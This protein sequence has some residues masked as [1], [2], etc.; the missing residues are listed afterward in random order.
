MSLKSKEGIKNE[1]NQKIK[2]TSNMNRTSKMKTTSEMK[3]T[4]K[5]KTTS[6]IKMTAMQ[7]FLHGF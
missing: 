2:M 5:M 3:M 7:S 6:N 4:T 1:D